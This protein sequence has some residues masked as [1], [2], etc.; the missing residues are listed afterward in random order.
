[1]FHS[2]F[3]T[4]GFITNQNCH[5]FA[6]GGDE[7]TVMAHNGVLPDIVQP[8]PRGS[9]FG[10]PRGRRGL[11]PPRTV[12]AAGLLGRTHR[13]RGLAGRGQDDRLDRRPPLQAHRE[14]PQR[15]PRANA[16]ASRSTRTAHR[17]SLR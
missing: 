4:H 7:R 12:R 9:A 1:M 14:P 6:I 11:P 10:H 5:P 16:S 13:A 15:T 2:R 8:R 17:W 3:A